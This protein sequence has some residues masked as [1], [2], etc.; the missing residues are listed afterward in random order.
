MGYTKITYNCDA[1]VSTNLW[2]YGVYTVHHINITVKLHHSQLTLKCTPSV[3]S[4]KFWNFFILI[5]LGLIF[6]LCSV[7]T[8]RTQTL[9]S[10]YSFLQMESNKIVL[11]FAQK[12]LIF[13]CL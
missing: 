7:Q 3:K 11:R 13:S 9:L 2:P 6:L 8:V 5:H 12:S 1:Q 4:H 10:F